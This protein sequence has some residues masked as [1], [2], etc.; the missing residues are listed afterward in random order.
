MLQI[1]ADEPERL[2]RVTFGGRVDPEELKGGYERVHALLAKMPPG[3]RLLVD[4]SGLESMDLSCAMQ[5]GRT[6]DL[7]DEK[8]VSQIVRILPDPRKDIGLNI[9]SLFHYGSH[10][11]IVTCG[12]LDEATKVLSV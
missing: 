7:F 1:E 6:M 12:N 2:L 4:L 5:I 10:V 9:L 8:G 11:R 3:F